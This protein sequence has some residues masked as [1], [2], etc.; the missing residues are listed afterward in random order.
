MR[1]NLVPIDYAS[2]AQAMVRAAEKR[3]RSR[4]IRLV[5]PTAR[6]GAGRGDFVL[7]G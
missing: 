3:M 6:R 4:R 1:T 2:L 5:G 7:E